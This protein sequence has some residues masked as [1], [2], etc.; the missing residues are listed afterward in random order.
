MQEDTALLAGAFSEFVAASTRLELSY[1][2]LQAEVAELSQAL[3][4]RNRALSESRDQNRSVSQR[5][6]RILEVIPCGVLVVDESGSVLLANEEASRLL[7]LY[8]R[9]AIFP[10]L[11]LEPA[12]ALL[13]QS[14]SEQ[15]L[16]FGEGQEQRWMAVRRAMLTDTNGFGSKSRAEA[17]WTLRDISQHKR[18]EREREA[19]RG[20]TALAQVS[21]LLAHEIRNPLASL[22]LF[23]GLIADH[24]EQ[25]DQWISHLRAGI[26]TLSA[27]VNNVL[28]LQ[29]NTFLPLEEV[30]VNSECALAV[31]FL[32]PLAEQAVVE[33]A[34][35]SEDTVAV[36]RAHRSAFHQILLNLCSNAL[37][38]TA[39]NGRV[40]VVC[41]AS[42]TDSPTLRISVTDTGIGIAPEHLPHIF[43]AGFSGSGTTS[44]LGLAVCKRLVEQLGGRLHV[45]SGLGRGSTFTL[46]L[47]KA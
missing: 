8:N 31:S 39:A 13:L 1:R 18:M 19:A 14:F 40:Q 25:R 30:D 44:G 6:E 3:L 32:Q 38:H 43:E 42:L 34:F 41:H 7:D 45:E 17:V 9:D 22:E 35:F 2:D 5:L 20:T 26:R 27:T 28:T 12:N 23:A 36:G 47:A 24:P 16:S 46:E 11:S 21:A 4:E 10:R 37:R 15:E 29:S 33:L